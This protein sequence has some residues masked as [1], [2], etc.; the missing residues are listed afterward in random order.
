MNN[1]STYTVDWET[2][3]DTYLVFLCKLTEARWL[4]V[5]FKAT[6]IIEIPTF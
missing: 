5:P 4:N 1:D 6:I 3:T 2:D